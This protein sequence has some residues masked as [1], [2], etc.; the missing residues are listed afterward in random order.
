MGTVEWQNAPIFV[1]LLLRNKR[2]RVQAPET[3]GRFK[4]IHCGEKLGPNQGG[5]SS[6]S[7]TAVNDGARDS[8][9]LNT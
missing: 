4:C 7:G 1:L 3:A 6:S 2:K 9:R 5:L 8:I